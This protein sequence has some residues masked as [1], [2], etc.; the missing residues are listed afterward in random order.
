MRSSRRRRRLLRSWTIAAE[1]LGI[2]VG[3][4][5]D[6]IV[7]RQFGTGEGTLCE[8]IHDWK[9]RF[10][11]K[12]LEGEAKRLGMAWS[13]LGDDYLSYDRE[14]FIDTLKD[15]GWCGTGDPP[16]WYAERPGVG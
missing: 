12:E 2:E 13:G 5:R 8:S 15:W 6:F 16:V 7:V 14:Q 3:E 1:D 10:P 11:W 4:Y 9:G